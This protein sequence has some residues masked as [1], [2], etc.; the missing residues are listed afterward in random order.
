VVKKGLIIGILGKNLVTIWLR[1]VTEP[2]TAGRVIVTDRGKCVRGIK[3]LS[4]M[5]KITGTCRPACA[6][7][8]NNYVVPRYGNDTTCSA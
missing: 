1:A 3:G 5:G 4:D 6:C 2:R 7:N 8:S